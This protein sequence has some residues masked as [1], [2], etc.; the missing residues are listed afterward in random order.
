MS[1]IKDVLQE[2]KER[3]ERMEKAYLK[4]I[5]E[6]PKGSVI[7]KKIGNKRYPYLTYRKDN[8]IVWDY[9]KLNDEELEE[10]KANIEKRRR[11]VLS[12]K[13]VRKEYEYIRRI[14]KK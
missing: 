14:L 12:L 3:L 9:L 11:L 13:N 4:K 6:L 1:I 2:E 5:E 10:L 7:M 8:K